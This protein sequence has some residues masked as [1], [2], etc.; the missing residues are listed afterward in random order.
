MAWVVLTRD[1]ILQGIQTGDSPIYLPS[2][3]I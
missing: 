1:D 3:M 2:G